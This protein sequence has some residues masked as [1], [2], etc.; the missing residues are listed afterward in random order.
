MKSLLNDIKQSDKTI[1]ILGWPAKATLMSYTYELEKY[2]SFVFDDNDLK[3]G[4]YTPGK[5]FVVLPT[6]DIYETKPDY[7]LILAWNY[8]EPLMKKY[9][10]TGAKFII[11]F[12]EPKVV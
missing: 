6:K 10:E 9:A 4:R 8:A 3:V 12:P 11:P 5:Q 1:A 7:L 2:I